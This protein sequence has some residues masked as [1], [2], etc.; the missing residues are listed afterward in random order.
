MEPVIPK[1]NDK[2]EP[3][4]IKQLEPNKSYLVEKI[5][6]DNKYLDFL[7]IHMSNNPEVF[8]FKVYNENEEIFSSLKNTYEILIERLNISFDI[9]LNEN[10]IYFGYIFDYCKLSDPHYEFIIKQMIFMI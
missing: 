4:F 1:N 9:N 7:I 8:G 3:K 2:D 6:Y 10:D 5:Q